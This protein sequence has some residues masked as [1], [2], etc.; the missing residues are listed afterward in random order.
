MKIKTKGTSV[1]SGAPS[2]VP[3][4]GSTLMYLDTTIP[5]KEQNDR[6]NATE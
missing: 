5:S 3:K 6:Q 2:I 1:K 4:Y